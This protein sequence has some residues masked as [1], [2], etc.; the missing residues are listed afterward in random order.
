MDGQGNLEGRDVYGQLDQ[1]TWGVPEGTD[2][3]GNLPGD[4]MGNP[5]SDPGVLDQV[6]DIITGIFG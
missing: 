6:L 3:L 5:A 2:A 4:V 1:G